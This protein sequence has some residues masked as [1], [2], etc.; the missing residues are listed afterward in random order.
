MSDGC[1]RECC[2]GLTDETPVEIVNRPGLPSIA[3]RAG[4]WTTF[5]ASMH[6]KLSRSA[7]LSALRTRTDDDPAVAIIDAWAA[8]AD[9]LTFYTERIANEHYLR[10][11]TEHRSVCDLVSLIGY[12]LASGVAAHTWLAF[13][14]ETAAGAPAVAVLPSGVR[15]QSLPGPGELPQTFE[16]TQEVAGVG[17]WNRPRVSL[18]RPRTPR[19]G[20][21]TVLFDGAA[22]GLGPGD[23][24]LFVAGRQPW[25]AKAAR[26]AKARVVEVTADPVARHT[27]VTFGPQ[28]TGLDL[29]AGD[30]V[31]V[32]VLE[33]QAALF[34]FNA[35]D[36]R[37]FEKSVAAGL[38]NALKLTGSRLD[39]NFTPPKKDDV[40]LDGLY[41]GVGPATWAVLT[42]GSTS[43]LGRVTSVA[44]A[45]TADYGLSGR[46]TA[47]ALDIPDTDVSDSNEAA[48]AW[49]DTR[50]TV[51]EFHS[52]RLPLAD[53][54]VDEPLS[55]PVIPLAAPL[56]PS[57]DRQVLV[58]GKRARARFR[59]AL[60]APLLDVTVLSVRAAAEPPG[61]LRWTVRTDDGDD[62]TVVDLPGAVTY[63]PARASDEVIGEVVTVA[64]T[65]TPV[66]PAELVLRT[67]L[68]NVYDL[69]GATPVEL[70]GNV[71][72]ATHGEAVVGE[73]LG[74]AD[75]ARPF[76][77]FT[78]RRKPLT[79]VPAQTFTG[80]ASTLQ[81]RVNGVV[82]HEIPTLYGAGPRDRVHVT[83][84]AD[85]G[86]TT[87][88]FGDGT[89]GAAAPTGADNVTASYRC[90]IGTPGNVGADRLTLPMV[91]PLGLKAVT[92][93]LAA[94]G[95]QDP[96]SMA[97][98]RVNAPRS[99]L[100][101][102]RVVSLQDYAD[103]ATAYASIGK[104]AA[105]WT[106]DGTRRGIAVTIAAAR[107]GTPSPALLDSLEQALLAAG[108]PRVP[109][110]VADHRSAAFAVR[111]ALRV[112]ADHDAAQ[113]RD[114]VAAALSAA[115]SFEARTFGQDVPLSEVTKVIHAVDGVVAVRFDALHRQDEAITLSTRLT[116]YAPLPG[117]PPDA[118]P[119]EILTLAADALDLEVGW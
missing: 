13:T 55:G 6:A 7:A 91:R 50:Q 95:G 78:L 105:H 51:V 15:V 61:Q 9:V 38:G 10:T 82:W 99:V 63:L 29:V 49:V 35:P 58:R 102:G 113:V 84:T 117:S 44:V 37:L 108:N 66:P 21:S 20:D 101:L 71:A 47:L 80:G 73:V 28:L 26:W 87:V 22:T 94:G 107:P 45:S 118:S 109:L 96:Q 83:R 52:R 106:W 14:L 67:P 11:A 25:T 114:G 64:G 88:L 79:F 2:T 27:L 19:T 3:Y 97:D 116:A 93:P 39:W 89:T 60:P 12:R 70:Y 48:P 77:Q 34:G 92:N 65:T 54:A 100:T 72:A 103:F 56:P 74:G 59:S 68:G 41:E 112:A 115:Y 90:G 86:T 18:T 81:V 36:P 23:S 119:A 24:L 30:E 17:A 75:A 85:D 62:H 69:R 104:A 5:R 32:H 16:T 8:A 76:Q 53:V 33:R 111:A 31:T 42:T 4:T 98:A 43:T 110:V 40:R 57:A 1:G 46:V